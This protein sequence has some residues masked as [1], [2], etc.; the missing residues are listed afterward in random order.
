MGSA[1]ADSRERGC[2]SGHTTEQFELLE[3]TVMSRETAIRT[4]R[5]DNVQADDVYVLFSSV[6]RTIESVLCLLRGFI[7]QQKVPFL[8]VHTCACNVLARCKCSRRSSQDFC[9]GALKDGVKA[10]YGF[11]KAVVDNKQP[12]RLSFSAHDN[13]V[14]ALLNVLQID[15]GSQIAQYGTMLAS[16]VCE[17]KASHEPL[18]KPRSENEEVFYAG[19]TW[20]PLCP[21]SHFESV[22]FLSY[23][24][25]TDQRTA[26]RHRSHPRVLCN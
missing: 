15:V 19:H 20:D 18:I 22:E 8:Y 1:A 14:G 17:D 7:E 9:Y 24:A 11:V 26:R 5:G 10:V 25:S 23:K 12:A 13:S 3:Q 2:N 21:F 16:E 4:A 6:P